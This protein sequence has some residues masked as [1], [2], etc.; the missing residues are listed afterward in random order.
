[1]AELLEGKTA[2]VY[3]SGGGIGGGVARTFAREGAKVFLVGRTREKLDAVADVAEA[4]AFLAS[5]G[6]A[7]LTGG[8]TN[9]TSG[10]VLR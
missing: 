5:D 6:A 4:A 10:L 7:G 2:V 9:V 1:M 8:M 3:G